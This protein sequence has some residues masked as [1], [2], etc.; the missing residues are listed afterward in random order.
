MSMPLTR[1]LTDNAALRGMGALFLETTRGQAIGAS[2][3]MPTM[4]RMGARVI[5]RPQTEIGAL[6]ENVDLTWY[7]AE[8]RRLGEEIQT[9]QADT[10]ALAGDGAEDHLARIMELASQR[11]ANADEMRDLAIGRGYVVPVEQLNEQYADIG[12]TFD[13]AVSAEDAEAIAQERREQIIRDAIISRSPGGLVQGV[14][15][16]GASLLA[17]ATDPVEVATMF[18]PVVGQARAAR[19]VARYGAVQG[20]V[21]TGAIE[22]AVG[23]A[24]TEPLYYGLSRELQLDYG[25]TDALFNI[26]LGAAFGGALGG[27]L[28]TMSRRTGNRQVSLEASVERDMAEV[29][30]R[31]F[32]TDRPVDV[33]AFLG[34]RDLRTS[35]TLARVEGISFQVPDTLR[36]PEPVR[37][38]PVIELTDNAGEP[39]RFAD[40]AQAERVADESGGQVVTADNGFAVTVQSAGDFVR[41]P[42]GMPLDFPS[43]AEAEAFVASAAPDVLPADAR[44]I[45]QGDTFRV[46]TGM[47]DREIAAIEAGRASV[48]VP[49]GVNT[50]ERAALPEGETRID[51][52]VRGTVARQLQAET[53]A[54]RAKEAPVGIEADAR[55]MGRTTSEQSQA[56]MAAEIA[57]YEDMIGQIED[58]LLPGARAELE[59]AR[60]IDDRVNALEETMR[61]AL[62]CV[63]RS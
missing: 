20:R 14:G 41:T 19:F 25:M 63:A 50:Q 21:L 22:G 12:V 3:G 61:A 53:L 62:A 30:L 47:T 45:Q 59:A 42:D 38:Q 10:M 27:V 18:I 52:A 56:D 34:G 31:Q 5:G 23:Q 44:V 2:F 51:Q 55:T 57:E 40:R 13:F 24:I 16:F 37:T 4:G 28:G 33:D 9:L 1:P 17:M 8:D 54:R 15:M 60:E 39:V 29:A 35:T 7:E 11:R 58:D 26:G 43:R 6:A 49:R 32:A 36:T 46:S 48:E